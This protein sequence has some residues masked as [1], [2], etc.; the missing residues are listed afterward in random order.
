MIISKKTICIYIFCVSMIFV[1][2][3]SFQ[4]PEE[5]DEKKYIS[6]MPEDMLDSIQGNG[7]EFNDENR[8][9]AKYIMFTNVQYASDVLSLNV[10]AKSTVSYINGIFISVLLTNDTENK[11]D[12]VDLRPLQENLVTLFQKSLKDLPC[13]A[14]KDF[15]RSGFKCQNMYKVIY[16]TNTDSLN[17][18]RQKLGFKSNKILT[19]SI[20]P[21]K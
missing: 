19:I 17:G 7:F 10:Y 2:G 13:S 11:G 21:I 1:A 15:L 5:V 9:Q 4:P 16:T 3:F 6:I 8:D 12:D 18:I 20:L 14:D